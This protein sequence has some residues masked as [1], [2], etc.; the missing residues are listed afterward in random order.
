[1]KEE[2][3]EKEEWLGFYVFPLCASTAPV[4]EKCG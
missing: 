3:G 2:E 1:M 4:S